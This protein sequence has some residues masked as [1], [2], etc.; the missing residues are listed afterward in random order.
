MTVPAACVIVADRHPTL[1]CALKRMLEP[2][3]EVI[4]MVDNVVSLI[5]AL[6]AQ[7]PDAIVLDVS[8]HAEGGRHLA[9][10][11]ARAHPRTPIILIEDDPDETGSGVP[12][13]R[14]VP[15][16]Q[17]AYLLRESVAAAI[18]AASTCDS[19]EECDDPGPPGSGD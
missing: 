8:M 9:R 5:A 11:L 7:T 10:H 18:H 3:F 13:C 14:T 19:R 16:S 15:K 17:A 6:G 1:L 4:A 12:G 2:Q